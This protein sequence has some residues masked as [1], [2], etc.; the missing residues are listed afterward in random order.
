MTDGT[1]SSGTRSV[2]ASAHRVP[3]RLVR[4]TESGYYADRW[5]DA[6]PDGF[7][8]GPIVLRGSA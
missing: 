5:C 2:S 4:R 3:E 7:C 8:L 6:W 1:A